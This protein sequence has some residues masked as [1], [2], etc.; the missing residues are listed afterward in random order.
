ME[1]KDFE[2]VIPAVMSMPGRAD[3]VRELL[4]DLAKQCPGIKVHV[5]PQWYDKI[6][7]WRDVF[8]TISRS[9]QNITSSWILYFEDDAE[10][11]LDFGER[12]LPIINGVD[13]DCG[14]IAFFSEH[15]EDEARLDDA[16]S[17][18][19]EP[20]LPFVH[21]QGMAIRKEVAEAWSNSMVEWWDKA[22]KKYQKK[23]PDMALGHACYQA[24]YKILVHLPSLVQ[25]RQLLSAYGHTYY[26]HSTTF[27]R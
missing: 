18:L 22:K 21:S 14:A 4:K 12:S 17:V 24:G 16:D 13:S 23:A 6:P 1:W 25:H 2:A 15:R 10:L 5:M 3:S 26:P 27:G 20:K 8:I 11:A 7:N 9:L 19:Y